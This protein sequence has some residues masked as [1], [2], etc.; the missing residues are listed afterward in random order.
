MN[1]EQQAKLDEEAVATELEKELRRQLDDAQIKIGLL[2][3][4]LLDRKHEIVSYRAAITE[5]NKSIQD[6]RTTIAE[7]IVAL[8]NMRLRLRELFMENETLKRKARGPK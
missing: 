8:E 1:A 3:L 6:C 7:K 2:E 5:K 4:E